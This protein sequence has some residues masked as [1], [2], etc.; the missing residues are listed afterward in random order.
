VLALAPSL[1]P[2]AAGPN[3]GYSN[4]TA[5]RWSLGLGRALALTPSL[6][7]PPESPKIEHSKGTGGHNGEGERAIVVDCKFILVNP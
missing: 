6:P 1:P 4:G 5:E 7:P 3:I 2:P